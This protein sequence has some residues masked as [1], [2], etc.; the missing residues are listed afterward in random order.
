[1]FKLSKLGVYLG[2]HHHDSAK[3][4]FPSPSPRYRRTKPVRTFRPPNWRGH[5]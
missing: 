4:K 2:P 5:R 3:E 1:M